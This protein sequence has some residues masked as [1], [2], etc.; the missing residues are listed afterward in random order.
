MHEGVM[1][2]VLKLSHLSDSLSKRDVLCI[3]Y[4][5]KQCVRTNGA[6]LVFVQDTGGQVS[7]LFGRH[8]MTLMFR[9]DSLPPRDTI[10]DSEG[11]RRRA[12]R[13][14]TVC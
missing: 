14:R 10:V 2:Y 4:I 7:S 9:E 1:L 11:A 13:Q 5:D 8:D 6:Y 3:G 12:L